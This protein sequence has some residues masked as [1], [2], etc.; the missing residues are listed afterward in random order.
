MIQAETGF[1]L[2]YWHPLGVGQYVI[3]TLCNYSDIRENC[4]AFLTTHGLIGRLNA[5]DGGQFPLK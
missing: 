4:G 5:R 3:L 1:I 2:N